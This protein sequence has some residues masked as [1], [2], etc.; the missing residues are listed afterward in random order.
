[1]VNTIRMATFDFIESAGKAYKFTGEHARILTRMA[2]WPVLLKLVTFVGITAFG[3]EEN[4]LRQG[5]LL[6][7][8]YFA[9]G[10]LVAAA[11]R[12]ALLEENWPPKN[13]PAEKG[14][15]AS[16][17]QNRSNA[18]LAAAII[19]VLTKLALSF[20]TGMTMFEMQKA[21]VST[22]AEPTMG[23]FLAACAALAF[24]IWAFRFTWLYVPV[25][26]GLS[27]Q[28]FIKRIKAFMTSIYMIGLWLLCFVPLAL[29][30]ILASEILSSLFPG[31]D[32]DTPSA[33]YTYLMLCV[34]V[35]MEAAVMIISSVGM[36]YAVR[37]IF[38]GREGMSV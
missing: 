29:V 11:I 6:L 35:M 25:A 1:M 18:I 30:L 4:V 31:I 14:V 9:E 28:G 22:Q 21:D 2:F 27:L 13:P 36:A 7:P 37:E 5:L 15:K 10:W 38:D 26:L 3:L 19:Y 16:I 32:S 24:V 33:A 23:M 34:Q 8:A 17:L 20:L 12:I